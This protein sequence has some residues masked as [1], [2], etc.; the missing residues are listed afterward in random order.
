[1]KNYCEDHVKMLTEIVEL[2]SKF[3]SLPD[4][5]KLV[6]MR[7]IQEDSERRKDKL[8]TDLAVYSIII[9]TI[10]NIDK[11]VAVIGKLL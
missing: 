4:K 6:T 1:M 7:A 8:R 3:D 2:S 11:I 5:I 9:A 10:S